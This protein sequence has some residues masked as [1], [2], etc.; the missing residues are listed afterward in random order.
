[1]IIVKP[2]SRI[3]DREPFRVTLDFAR[4]ETTPDARE[5]VLFGD[6]TA[7]FRKTH[8]ELTFLKLPASAFDGNTVYV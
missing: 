7:A 6:F 1:M 4:M 8:P 3:G 2:D 5:I